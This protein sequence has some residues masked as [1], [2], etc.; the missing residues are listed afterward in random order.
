MLLPPPSAWTQADL[1][2]RGR[3]DGISQIPERCPVAAVLLPVAEVDGWAVAEIGAPARGRAASRRIALEV[4]VQQEQD[5]LRS[6]GFRFVPGDVLR[7][8]QD[9]ALA[10]GCLRAEQ[11]QPAPAPDRV[12]E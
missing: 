1:R 12:V 2:I 11:D 7:R 10:H 4:V 9:A 5:R 3:P 6:V 8:F